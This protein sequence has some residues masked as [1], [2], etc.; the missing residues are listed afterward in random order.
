[1]DYVSSSAMHFMGY[2]IDYLFVPVELY[3][4]QI[5]ALS[6]MIVVAFIWMAYEIRGYQASLK[7]WSALA[8]DRFQD[9]MDTRREA[10]ASY[11]RWKREQQRSRRWLPGVIIDYF[12]SLSSGDDFQRPQHGDSSEQT[13]TSPQTSGATAMEVEEEEEEIAS[14]PESE[15][16]RRYRHLELSE[17]SDTELWMQAHD[18]EDMDVEEN[19]QHAAGDGAQLDLEPQ[20]QDMV[21]ARDLALRVYEQRRQQALDRGDFEALDAL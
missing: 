8:D 11:M 1:M 12:G 20:L 9:E 4:W 5:L 3:V 19:N 2:V 16:R 6:S 21:R 17:A 14:E 7:S 10:F 18:H 15:K 13:E